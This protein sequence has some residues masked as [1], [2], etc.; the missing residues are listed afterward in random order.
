MTAVRRPR[1]RGSGVRQSGVQTFGV[2]TFGVQAF[3]CSGRRG[4]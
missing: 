3:R 4:G 2:Q 1:R